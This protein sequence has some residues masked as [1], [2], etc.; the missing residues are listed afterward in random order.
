[1]SAAPRSLRHDEDHPCPKVNKSLTL[2]EVGDIPQGDPYAYRRFFLHRWQAY[3]KTFP[4]VSALA[5]EFMVDRAT[6]RAWMNGEAGPTG[7][8]VDY[9]QNGAGPE[10]RETYLRA[11][12]G[13]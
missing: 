5:R 1:M 12:K 11:V 7:W 13:R 10:I 4:S 6:A 9:V 3:C 8:A 2:R